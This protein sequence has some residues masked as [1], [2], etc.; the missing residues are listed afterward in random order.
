[1]MKWSIFTKIKLFDD[2]CFGG[3]GKHHTMKMINFCPCL[4]LQFTNDNQFQ[5]FINQFIICDVFIYL[6]HCMEDT[7]DSIIRKKLFTL[8][9]NN[10]YV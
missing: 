1:M 5:Q 6:Y 3:N 2:G 10:I 8:T 7:N 4:L 9:N